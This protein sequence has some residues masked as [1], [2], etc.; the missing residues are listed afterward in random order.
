MGK[1]IT[2]CGIPGIQTLDY[3]SQPCVI[4]AERECGADNEAAVQVLALQ[5]M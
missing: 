5:Q 3:S 1:S 4:G 2:R